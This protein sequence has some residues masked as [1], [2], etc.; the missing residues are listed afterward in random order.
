LTFQYLRGAY[1]KDEEGFFTMDCSDR[2]KGNG[3]K[4]KEWRFRIDVR[5]KLLRG[6]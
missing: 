4:L 6:W 3:F 2:K 5:R 1:N